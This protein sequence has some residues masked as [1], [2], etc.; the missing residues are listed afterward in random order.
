M[1]IV[2]ACLELLDA[3]EDP[4]VGRIAGAAGVTRQTVYAH[5]E[6]RQELLR[7]ALT[8]LTA[9]VA[10]DLAATEPARGELAD[11]VERWTETVWRTIERRPALVNPALQGV[12]PAPGDIVEA[13]ELV[14]RE[15][16]TLAR[17][18][19]RERSLPRSLTTDWLVRAVLAHGHAA[20][21]E[22]AAG[23]MSRRAAG[24]AFRHGVRALLLGPC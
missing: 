21:E 22:V 17:R 4:S 12:P 10:A 13:H 3:G 19:R 8:T 1:A 23:R 24:V 2:G 16:R 11:A 7:A 20:G 14:L 9:E 15:L 5:F 6:S 18:A